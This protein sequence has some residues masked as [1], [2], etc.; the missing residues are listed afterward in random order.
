VI[1]HAETRDVHHPR[2]VGEPTEQ[3][4][5]ESEELRSCQT[6]VLEDDSAIDMLEEPIDR[7]H[8]RRVET[9]IRVGYSSVHRARPIDQIEAGDDLV[10]ERLISG[11]QGPWSIYSDKDLRRSHLTQSGDLLAHRLRTV[12]SDHEHGWIEGSLSRWCVSR[13]HWPRIPVISLGLV[14]LLCSRSVI[15]SYE[16]KFIFLKTRKVAGSSLELYL[17]QFC[18]PDDIVTPLMVHEEEQIDPDTMRAPTDARSRPAMPWELNTDKVKKMIERRKWPVTKNWFSHQ[19]ASDVRRRAG[20]PTWNES[21]K[22]TVVRNPWDRVVSS[23]YWQKSNR[24]DRFTLDQAVERAANN[25]IIYTIRNEVAVD[26]VIR[27]ENLLSDF[28]DVCDRIGIS[29]PTELPRLKS[30][31]RPPGVAPADILSTKQV[32]RIAYLCR[33]EIDLFGYEYDPI[34]SR[35]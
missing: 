15:L 4:A 1:D 31:S 21:F 6:I 10:A 26:H 11:H 12:E 17:R 14:R 2:F 19:W 25:W 32:N 28:G 35:P 27:F 7:R 13:H 22:F 18:G 5:G 9:M 16:H 24:G 8:D 3:L 30:T 23:Y 33:K 20:Q 29:R 34:S